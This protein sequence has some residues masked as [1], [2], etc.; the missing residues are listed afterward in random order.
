[1]EFKLILVFLLMPM[2]VFGAPF[3]TNL[4][5]GRQKSESN[6]S[7][8]RNQTKGELQL[9]EDEPFPESTSA[10]PDDRMNTNKLKLYGRLFGNF[11]GALQT[12]IEDAA[13]TKTPEQLDLSSIQEK[14]ASTR[15]KID[16]EEGVKNPLEKLVAD[17]RRW[18]EDLRERKVFFLTTNILPGLVSAWRSVMESLNPPPPL[19]PADG[20]TG[21]LDLE[22]EPI[23]SNMSQKIRSYLPASRTNSLETFGKFL[24]FLN[25]GQPTKS[26]KL[27]E[28]PAPRVNGVVMLELFG[29]IFGLTWNILSQIGTLLKL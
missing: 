26:A 6:I 12:G 15:R 18:Q 4:F 9:P 10:A 16:G 20:D 21:G 29:S 8:L 7:D 13:R 27:V 25:T 23:D 1:M 24:K 22:D 11:I 17:G 14:K 2:M 19:S 3:L 28:D 5:P